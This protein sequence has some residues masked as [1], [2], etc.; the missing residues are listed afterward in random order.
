MSDNNINPVMNQMKKWFDNKLVAPPPPTK[1]TTTINP[2]NTFIGDLNQVITP[3]NIQ[4]ITHEENIEQTHEQVID[5]LQAIFNTLTHTDQLNYYSSGSI[6][7]SVAATTGTRAN[8]ISETIVSYINP[9]YDLY[10]DSCMI[11]GMPARGTPPILPNPV[12]YTQT[13]LSF[14][15]NTTTVV[16]DTEY[17]PTIINQPATAFL[18]FSANWLETLRR[19]IIF[20]SGDSLIMNIY[21]SGSDEFYAGVCFK[22]YYKLTDP[23]NK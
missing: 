23:I 2:F 1:G 3:K 5:L 6:V 11:I 18:Q 15:R 20:R 13:G 7:F 17:A 16:P 8:P 21:N 10:L 19:P 12:D 9:Y 4:P 22:G 14:L